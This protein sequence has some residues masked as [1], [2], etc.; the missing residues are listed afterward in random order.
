[1]FKPMHVHLKYTPAQVQLDL[2]SHWP[3]WASMCENLTLHVIHDMYKTIT[4]LSITC[5]PKL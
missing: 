4:F 3:I 1:M 2:L 5:K